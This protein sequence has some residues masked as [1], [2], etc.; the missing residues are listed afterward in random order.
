MTSPSG[1]PFW[2]AGRAMCLPMQRITHHGQH[3]HRA[4]VLEAARVTPDS[5]YPMD[6]RTY[7]GATSRGRLLTEHFSR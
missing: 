1:S 5:A 3:R 4:H 2:P 7:L 6:G